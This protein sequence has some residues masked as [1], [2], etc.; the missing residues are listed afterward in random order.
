MTMLRTIQKPWL[1]FLPAKHAQ[2][3]LVPLPGV[4]E[5]TLLSALHQ[6]ATNQIYTLTDGQPYATRDLY[7]YNAMRQALELKPLSLELPRRGLSLIARLGRLSNRAPFLHLSV[8]H[9]LS[10]IE[11]YSCEKIQRELG[12]R[13]SANLIELIPAF[14]KNYEQALDSVK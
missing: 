1:P 9:K 12:W 13:P 8:L 14:I 6:K 4:I 7:N 3:A 5:A 2:R 11:S 10:T